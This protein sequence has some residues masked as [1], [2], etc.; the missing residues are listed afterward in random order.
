MNMK[1]KLLVSAALCAMFAS[2][3]VK[4]S[5]IGF[6]NDPV[7]MQKSTAVQG[8]LMQREDNMA[9]LKKAISVE[10]N[11]IKARAQALEENRENLS[12]K[13]IGEKQ[14]E[15]QNSIRDLQIRVQKAQ[16]DLQEELNAAILKFRTE[17]VDPVV[18]DLARENDFEAI[19]NKNMAYYID[20]KLD[21]TDKAIERINARMPKLEMNTIK[22][23]KN[24]EEKVAPVVAQ[25]A[26][27]KIEK[28]T[29]AKPKAKM[30]KKAKAKK[31]VKAVK[32]EADEQ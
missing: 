18:K 20:E 31:T 5:D 24:T 13:E 28:K 22:L 30:A 8:I 25:E 15:I 10:E 3:N 12:N 7:L 21:V 17:A 29:V 1:S 19:L 4:A 27:V 9:K 11:K 2:S 6:I 26:P 16:Q 14:D 32:K 23:E